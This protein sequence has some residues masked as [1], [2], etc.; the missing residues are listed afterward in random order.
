MT[1]EIFF[2]PL[3]V[4]IDDKNI[5]YLENYEEKIYPIVIEL[6]NGKVSKVYYL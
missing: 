3:S 4:L 1:H 6:V 2:N 5:F